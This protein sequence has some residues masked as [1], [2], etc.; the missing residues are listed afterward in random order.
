MKQKLVISSGKHTGKDLRQ[1]IKKN[2]FEE[3]FHIYCFDLNENVR[4]HLEKVF[5][6]FQEQ[7]EYLKHFKDVCQPE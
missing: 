4:S 6:Q 1:I 2:D 7:V 5:P 3:L